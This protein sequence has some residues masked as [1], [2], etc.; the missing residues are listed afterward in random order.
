MPPARRR[1]QVV[2]RDMLVGLVR[3]A[4]HR[5]VTPLGG[6]GDLP[7]LIWQ[8]AR[9]G[10]V[11]VFLGAGNITA[12]AH[13]L[14]GQ[15]Q[16][17]AA[18]HAGPRA[19]ANDPALQRIGGMMALATSHPHLIDRL[20][21]PRGRLTPMR[22]WARRPGSRTGGP[23]EVLFRPADTEDLAAFLK[24][25][26]RRRAGHR[27][28]RRLEPA[29]ARRRHQGRGDPPD[30]RLH[31]HRRRRQRSRGRRRCARSQRGADGARACAG[32][33][34]VP[35]RHPGHDRRRLPDQ[36]RRLWRR[37]GGG[38]GLGRGR[39]PRRQGHRRDAVRARPSL[40]PQ[41]CAGGL[42]LH[43]GAAAAPRPA[44]SSR[45]PRRI[46][47]IDSARSRTRSRAAAPAARPSP[48]RPATRRG[49]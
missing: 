24:A 35:E 10:D 1:S 41:Q 43:L 29:G 25:L 31:R 14:P 22:R 39:R 4:G 23:A 12:W 20:P 15:I 36:C 21:K 11:V 8:M 47:E 6:P 13:A 34:G 3:H 5:D 32:R 44:T 33:A 42:D 37:A 16:Q 30:A 38:A 26:P 40:S 7:G 2:N 49:S 46:A 18:E 45:S 27:A 9:P 17:I 28:G 19:I 48:I